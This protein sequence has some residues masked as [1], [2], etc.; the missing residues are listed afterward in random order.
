MVILMGQI[1][2][3]MGQIGVEGRWKI[4]GVRIVI[5]GLLHVGVPLMCSCS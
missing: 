3:L 1:E 2:M 4:D 5:G